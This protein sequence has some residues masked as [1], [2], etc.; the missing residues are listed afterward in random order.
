MAIGLIKVPKWVAIINGQECEVANAI[1][2][3]YVAQA[4]GA[5]PPSPAYAKFAAE[6]KARADAGQRVELSIPFERKG[7][8]EIV[9]TDTVALAVATLGGDPDDRR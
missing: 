9:A 3:H 2:E 5:R 4:C 8:V 1:Y 7:F 6:C